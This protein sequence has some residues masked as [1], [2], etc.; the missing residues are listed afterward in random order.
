MTRLVVQALIVPLV[1]AGCSGAGPS[2]TPP[3][4]NITRIE[5][6]SVPCST[7]TGDGCPPGI[8]RG[9]LYSL[10]VSMSISNSAE[11]TLAV[12]SARVELREN[13]TVTIGTAETPSAGTVPASIP[14][15]SSLELGFTMPVLPGATPTH[16]TVRASATGVS[17]DG[18][19]WQAAADLVVGDR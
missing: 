13:E 6:S 19:P 1:L 14:G 3:T 2:N 18:V 9:P 15:R 7:C 10:T 11:H 8:C 17:D 4:L 12:R 5:V 16:S